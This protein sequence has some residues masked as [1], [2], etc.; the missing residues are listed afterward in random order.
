MGGQNKNRGL[1]IDGHSLIAE[2]EKDFM[3][4]HRCYR[5]EENE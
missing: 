1:F 3:A 2:L 4:A 5:D